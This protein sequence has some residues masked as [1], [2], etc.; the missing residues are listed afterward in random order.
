MAFSEDPEDTIQQALEYLELGGAV[1]PPWILA[2][3]HHQNVLA[4]QGI[5]TLQL[6]RVGEEPVR[7]VVS[8]GGLLPCAVCASLV[9]RR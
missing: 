7:R 9:V 6:R 1:V 8:R 5:D 4:R 2:R 3:G